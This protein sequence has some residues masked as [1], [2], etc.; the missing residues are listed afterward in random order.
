M[1]RHARTVAVG[2]GIVLLVAATTSTDAAILWLGLPGGGSAALTTRAGRLPWMRVP[3]ADLPDVAGYALPAIADL[4][5]D[6][7]ADAL[8]GENG[9]DVLAFRNAGTTEVPRWERRTDWDPPVKDGG[10]PALGDIDGDGDADLLVGDADGSITAFE[11]VGS[12]RVPAWRARKGWN[13]ATG[14]RQAR[15]ALGDLDDDGR[16]DLVVGTEDG[17]VLAFTGTGDGGTPFARAEGWD[18]PTWSARIAPAIGDVD[19]DGHADLIVAD[20]NARSRAYGNTGS[21]W[22]EHRSW[23]PDDPGSGPAGPALAD[24]EL[25]PEPP[26]P[27]PHRRHH[28]RRGASRRSSW[29]RRSA[30]LHRST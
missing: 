3:S 21:G 17:T 4:D 27:P 25:D 16:T 24:G 11:N 1:T 28:P 5:G 6:G 14:A 12:R 9:R 15:P 8:V 2:A 26:P 19:G 10:A 20:G 22:D 30:A 29:H 18:G 13:L 23:A 7:V